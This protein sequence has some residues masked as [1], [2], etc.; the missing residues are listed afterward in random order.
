MK[1]HKADVFK[2]AKKA[3]KEFRGNLDI[4]L[5]S[6]KNTPAEVSYKLQG[7]DYGLTPYWI[8]YLYEI[9]PSKGSAYTVTINGFTGSAKVQSSGIPSLHKPL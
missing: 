2:I 8:V 1:F 3:T 9:E 7:D 4:K 6:P 5:I